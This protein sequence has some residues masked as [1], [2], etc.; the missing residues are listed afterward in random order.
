MTSKTEF[1]LLLE[2]IERD[3]GIPRQ[4]ILRLIEGAV[5]SA[6]V[7][8]MGRE[9]PVQATMDGETGE[10]KAAILKKA[11]EQVSD[12]L[13]EISLEAAKKINPAV[14]VDEDVPVAVDTMEF[15]RIAA[16][17]AKQ[18]ILQKLREVEKENLFKD[19]KKK[20]NLVITGS[21]YRVGHDK[22]V[23]VSLGKIEA[24]LKKEE[25]IPGERFS[26]GQPLKALVHSVEL[27]LRGP[28]VYLSRSAPG[29]VQG[30]LR[31]EVPEVHDGTVEILKVVREPAFRSKVLIKS[32]DPRVDPVGAC[33]GIKGTRIRPVINELHGEKIDLVL[34]G[35]NTEGMIAAALAPAKVS[36]VEVEDTEKKTARVFVEQDQLAGA[37]GK[38]GLNLKLTSELTGWN[39]T[40]EA[41]KKEDAGC[42]ML[43]AGGVEKKEEDAGCSMLDAG[44]E[45]EKSKQEEAAQAETAAASEGKKKVK[46]KK[47]KAAVEEKEKIS[48]EGQ[49]A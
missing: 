1:V 32:N 23:Y 31:L 24:I 27:D 15:S 43:D 49:T 2:T 11:V 14:K 25:Q 10:T 26:I 6:L 17:T 5:A 36:K 21:V 47:I 34:S 8:H 16:Q 30:L 40:V 48:E 13:A 46:A 39:I 19:F 18:V 20:E 28:Q 4:E 33:V 37:I 42:S 7:K 12:P 29:F 38:D 35:D 45:Q 22:T 44:G 9:I 41:V 3:K